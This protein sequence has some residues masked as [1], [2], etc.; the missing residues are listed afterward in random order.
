MTK[1]RFPTIK[2]ASDACEISIAGET[3]NPHVGES[4]YFVPYLSLGKALQLTEVLERIAEEDIE[5][6]EQLRAITEIAGV[7]AQ[8]IDHWDWTHPITGERLG[9]TDG[10]GKLN[11]PD[12]E[13]IQELSSDEVSFLIN[14]FFEAMSP[15]ENPQSASPE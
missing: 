2:R 10:N 3:I 8:V 11:R 7:V 5:V 12:V 4:V 6:V 13:A 15:E 9:K 14:E 1:K